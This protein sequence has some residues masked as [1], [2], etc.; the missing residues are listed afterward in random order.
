MNVFRFRRAL[1]RGT[2]L[3][4]SLPGAHS[5]LY[6]VRRP[7]YS[8]SNVGNAARLPPPPHVGRH[9]RVVVDV[10]D[11]PRS[12]INRWRSY[13]VAMVALRNGMTRVSVLPTFALRTRTELSDTARFTSR[14][15]RATNV[16][17]VYLS[18]PDGRKRFAH[19]VKN[20]RQRVRSAECNAV[21]SAGRRRDG[22]FERRLFR[23]LDTSLASPVNLCA[24]YAARV[25]LAKKATTVAAAYIRVTFRSRFLRQD[26]Q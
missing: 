12:A 1:S 8:P 16:A 22:G 7:I 4:R 6:T 14:R 2:S 20:R 18:L 9:R 5:A 23:V 3:Y 10:D 13:L 24:H 19:T 25:P 15:R 26:G 11:C 17:R 21:S